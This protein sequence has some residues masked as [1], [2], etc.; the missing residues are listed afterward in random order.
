MPIVAIQGMRLRST[1]QLLPAAGGPTTGTADAAGSPAVRLSVIG[2]STA[3]GAGVDT[4][5]AGFSGCLARELAARTGRP[6]E[7]EAVGQHGA[8]TRRIRHRLLPQVATNL[9]VAVLLAGG[10]DVLG[11]RS[12]AEWGAELSAIV[13]DLIDRADQVVVSGLP[14]FSDFPALPAIFGRYLAE[15]A[16]AFDE[17]TRQVCADRPRATMTD[18]AD[19]LPVGPDFF[20][21]DGFH[22]SASGYRQWAESVADYVKL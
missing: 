20:A 21:A 4:Q 10:N 5:D 3:T 16:N 9:S 15:R 7:W 2:E 19:I 17:V 22:P 8:T 1:L 14:P 13:D 12:P 11:K 18:S 6:V